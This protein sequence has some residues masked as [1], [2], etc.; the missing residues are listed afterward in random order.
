MGVPRI[1]RGPKMGIIRAT[2]IFNIIG[3]WYIKKGCCGP[4]LP[5][6]I[7]QGRIGPTD[8]AESDQI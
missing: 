8:Q 4:Y 3:F 6:L 5:V 2:T 1:Y 7:L